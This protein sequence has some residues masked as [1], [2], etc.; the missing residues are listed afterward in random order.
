MLK[1]SFRKARSKFHCLGVI[2]VTVLGVVGATAFA[3]PTAQ[4]DVR[5][6]P[7]PSGSVL[8]GRLTGPNDNGAYFVDAP[9]TDAAASR[10]VGQL[11]WDYMCTGSVINSNKKALVI[12]AAHCIG[13]NTG[14]GYEI[15]PAFRTALAQ[16]HVE[17]T[18]AFDGRTSPETRPYGTWKVADAWVVPG[19]NSDVAVLEIKPN[20]QGQ[21]IQDV[22]GGGFDIHA[23]ITPGEPV[24][25]TLIGYP[26]PEPFLLEAQSGCVGDYT[27]YL[28]EGNASIRRVAGQQEC[29]VGGGASGGP[30]VAAPSTP[31]GAPQVLTVLNSDGGADVPSVAGELLALADTPGQPTETAGNG[32]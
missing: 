27:L 16:D 32:S 12:T 24:R 1:T 2:G 11:A 29:W 13:T 15:S 3:A 21:L 6:Q 19:S 30:Y 18:P 14:G 26:G 4:A 10:A 5:P 9:Y 23:P 17:F 25:A 22:V 8:A 28:G 31:D 20:A 7:D